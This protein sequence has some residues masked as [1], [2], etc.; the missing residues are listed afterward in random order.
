MLSQTISH[1]RILNHLGGNLIGEVYIA[2]D[3]RLGRKVV[4]QILSEKFTRD[5]ERMN[6]LAQE[7]RSLSALNHPNIRM[8]YEVASGS[9]QGAL[10]YFIATEYVDGPNLRI[11]LSRRRFELE[12]ILDVLLQTAVG[13]SAAHAAGV[14]HRDLQPENIV[15]R[16][17]GYVKIIDFG[18]AKL[19]EQDSMMIELG[20][21][22]ELPLNE[23]TPDTI[24]EPMDETEL[25]EDEESEAGADAIKGDPYRTMPLDPTVR[26]KLEEAGVSP[27]PPGSSAGMWWAVGTTAYLS[28][29]QIRGEPIDERSDIFSLGVVAYEMCAGRLPFDGER[30]TA[31]LGS[32]LQ[33]QPPPLKKFMPGAPDELEWIIAKALSKDRDERYQT[34][35]ELISDLKRLKQRLDFEAEQERL[36]QSNSGGSRS[37]DKHRA[38][39]TSLI[40]SRDSSRRS[41]RASGRAPGSSQAFSGPIDSVA[42]L[43]L[44]NASDDPAAEYLSDG[45][46]ESIINTLSRLPR[47]RVMARSTVFRFKGRQVDPLEVGAELSVRAVF[48]GRLLQRG[49]NLV[50]KAELVDASDGALLWAEQYSRKSDDIFELEDEIARQISEHL[51]VKLS[52]EQ[53][54]GLAKR[55]TD[56]AEAYELY[57]RGRYFWNQRSLPGMK[58]G[59]EY[60]VQA[61]RRDPQYALAYAGMADCYLMLSV[62]QLPPREFVP[63]ARM[64]VTRALECDDQLAEAHASFGSLLFW[65]DWDFVKAEQEYQ[66]AIELNPNLP[67]THQWLAYLYGAQNRFDEAFDKMRRAQSLDP[68]SIVTTTNTGELLYRARRFE[69]AAAQCEKALDMDAQ[70]AKALYWRTMAWIASDKLTEA[71]TFLEAAMSGPDEARAIASVMLAVVCARTGRREQAQGI[72]D[73]LRQFAE[74]NYFPP[75]YF[76]VIAASLGDSDQAFAWLDKAYQERS[77]WMPWLKHEPL[78]D[79]LSQDARFSDLLRRVGLEP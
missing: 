32:I 71:A 6:R 78:L 47:L 9:S 30:A 46:T 69:E 10:H 21:I 7:A 19:L 51:K 50:I 33:A 54:Q 25:L 45:I 68:L 16:A 65:Y 43:P 44:S 31:L 17:D 67:E 74:K 49:E 53:R 76:A 18:L 66:R 57:L 29:E 3:T 59:I 79:S 11:H 64:L 34:T 41:G 40:G 22:P 4:L 62:Y 72:F 28:P 8:I 23:P 55:Y 36:E 26:A 70:F 5:G 61:I 27:L 1:Y 14:L 12:E 39:Q 24:T 15:L 42:V 58:K 52:S 56:N 37:S 2:E 20:A 13:L 48:T 38:P 77:G 63:K 35:R 75:Y 60:F 73:R